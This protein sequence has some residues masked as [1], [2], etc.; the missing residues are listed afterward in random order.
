M[1]AIP[2]SRSASGIRVR[3][4]LA[5]LACLFLWSQFAAA[6]HVHANGHPGDG[7]PHG[8]C[9][10]CVAHGAAAPPPSAA[11]ASIVPL[12]IATSPR[13]GPAICLP[14]PRRTP[15]APRAPPFVP[16]N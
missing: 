7:R 6:A 11:P 12:A 3:G 14:A 15:H 1:A 9:E 2:T 8:G 13:I 5:V 16:S 4:A 10:L